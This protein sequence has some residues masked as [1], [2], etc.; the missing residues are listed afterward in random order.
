MWSV[1]LWAVCIS[2]VLKLPSEL[3]TEKVPGVPN[4]AGKCVRGRERLTSHETPA[5]A[6]QW[7]RA[8][9]PLLRPRLQDGLL[10]L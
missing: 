7:A 6:G 3:C 5:L 8:V 10:S 2:C 9:T 1:P 4:D